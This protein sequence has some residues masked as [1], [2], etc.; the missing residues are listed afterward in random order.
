MQVGQLRH[1]LA[2]AVE[3]SAGVAGSVGPAASDAPGHAE[4]GRAEVR[5][6]QLD[7]AVEI[8]DR[9]GAEA[10]RRVFFTVAGSVLDNL[11]VGA[12]GATGP[13][14]SAAAIKIRRGVDWLG[15]GSKQR[16]LA[17]RTGKRR[18]LALGIG[19]W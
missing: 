7:D 4:P 13:A 11:L 10:Q 2:A 18:A 17:I 12:P 9:V 19:L 14:A 8:A 6:D 1:D 3:G 5:G 15:T 16:T